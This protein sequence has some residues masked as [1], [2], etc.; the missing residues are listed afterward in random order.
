MMLFELTKGEQVMEFAE[1]LT[2]KH[3][4]DKNR[5]YLKTLG[6]KLIRDGWTY[7]EV[8]AGQC[9]FKKGP[10]QIAM[11][12]PSWLKDLS[13]VVISYKGKPDATGYV[14]YG[15]TRYK[16]KSVIDDLEDILKEV[17]EEAA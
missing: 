1:Y 7:R 4:T 15:T 14:R 17:E 3:L 16:C 2:S 11:P 13:T 10:F 5:P 8:R 9:A 12:S 6:L